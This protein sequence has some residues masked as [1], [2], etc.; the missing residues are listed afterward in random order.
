MLS[1]TP[2][3][4]F[5]QLWGAQTSRTAANSVG[6]EDMVHHKDIAWHFARQFMQAPRKS[7][8][9]LHLASEENVG[10]HPTRI[11]VTL[12]S[13]WSKANI[14]WKIVTQMDLPNQNGAVLVSDCSEYRGFHRCWRTAK[15]IPAQCEQT[16]NLLSLVSELRKVKK[17]P[18]M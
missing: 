13:T 6:R 7:G 4:R 5:R 9:L 18:E 10:C 12:L 3:R 1:G 2:C 14:R 15:A 16:D 11:G 8:V 17:H